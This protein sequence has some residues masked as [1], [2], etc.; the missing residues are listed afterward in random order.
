MSSLGEYEQ[1]KLEQE[2][3]IAIL[4]LHRPDKMKC[5]TRSTR[6]MRMMTSVL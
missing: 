4:T 3:P 1:I 2:G 6:P 5:S